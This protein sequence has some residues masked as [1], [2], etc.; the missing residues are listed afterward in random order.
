MTQQIAIGVDIGGTS[1]KGL[2][3]DERGEVHAEI[4]RPTP[5]GD[6]SA[7]LTARVV[8]EIVAEFDCVDQT[9]VGVVVPGIIDERHGFALRSSNLGW[10]NVNVAERMQDRLGRPIVFGHDVRA[11]ALAEATWGAAAH[12]DGAVVFVAIGTGVAAGL[13]IDGRPVSGGGWAGEIGQV[14][15]TRGP[16]AGDRVEQLIS[17]SAIARRAGATNARDVVRRIDEGDAEAIAIW[18][19]SVD[20]LAESLA[21]LIAAVGPSIVV[22]GGGLSL[23]GDA[24]FAPLGAALRARL[25]LLRVPEIRPAT[26]GDRAAALGAAELTGFRR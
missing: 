5:Q 22:V 14:L 1:I 2:V 4:R 12:R 23:A 24:L 10:S 7:E 16:H 21:H 18:H 13:L 11:G 26:L 19:E 6:S 9:P 8:A 17:A 3:V 20:F 25:R 15:I